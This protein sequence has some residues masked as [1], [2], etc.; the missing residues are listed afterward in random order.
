MSVKES[1][2]RSHFKAIYTKLGVGSQPELLS[3]IMSSLARTKM[4]LI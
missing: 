2:I 4:D 1:T 3:K